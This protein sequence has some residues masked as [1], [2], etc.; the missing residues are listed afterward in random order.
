[1][2]HKEENT[3]KGIK[4]INAAEGTGGKEHYNL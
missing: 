3:V 4:A 1:M 2:A